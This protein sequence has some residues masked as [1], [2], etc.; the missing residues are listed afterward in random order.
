MSMAEST[1]RALLGLLGDMSSVHCIHIS[2]P[3]QGS[4]WLTIDSW[5]NYRNEHNTM[6]L[7][8]DEACSA[9][10]V[11]LVG[12]L[13]QL[14]LSHPPFAHTSPELLP[15]HLSRFLAI[16]TRDFGDSLAV[17]GGP[18]VS[19][20]NQ[21]LTPQY[22][23]QILT[24]LRP[25]FQNL[26]EG[27]FKF[28]SELLLSCICL[29]SPTE[30]GSLSGN[31]VN[32]HKKAVDVLSDLLYS[33]PATGWLQKAENAKHATAVWKCLQI[34]TSGAMWW[35][36]GSGIF[37]RSLERL[38][39]RFCELVVISSGV[40]CLTIYRLDV[41]SYFPQL[42]HFSGRRYEWI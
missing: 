26:R 33:V 20:D 7:L 30:G 9:T 18:I 17:G 2:S 27:G 31:W 24:E 19:H 6:T 23:L 41:K 40:S 11:Q 42:P 22:G 5:I 16:W 14:L 36:K 35:G 39:R 1:K 13:L 32:T 12:F 3:P 15:E 10:L 28:V 38:A 21:R 4:A 8:L 25:S 34:L 37:E 29:L